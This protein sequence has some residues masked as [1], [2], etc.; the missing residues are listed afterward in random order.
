MKI[1]QIEAIPL[2][3]RLR[4]PFHGG[5]YYINSR[6]TIVTRGGA[7]RVGLSGR[8]MAGMRMR[9]TSDLSDSE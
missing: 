2:V 9:T 8:Y 3:R 6:N 4:E 7:W 1:K 5:T